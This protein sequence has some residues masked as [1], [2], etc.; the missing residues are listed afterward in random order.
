MFRET[1]WLNLEY[2]FDQLLNLLRWLWILIKELILLLADVSIKMYFIVAGFVFLSVMVFLFF[3]LRKLER[4]IKVASVV[5]FKEE[6][7]SPQ[8]RSC[9]WKDIKNKINSDNVEDW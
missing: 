9:K 5:N 7:K 3:K 2:L 4:K 6:E 1:K 8:D